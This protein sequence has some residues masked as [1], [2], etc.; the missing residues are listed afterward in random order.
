MKKKPL[1][2]QGMISNIQSV[3]NQSESQSLQLCITQVGDV[4][5]NS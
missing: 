2:V 3:A 1:L 4:S 5:L